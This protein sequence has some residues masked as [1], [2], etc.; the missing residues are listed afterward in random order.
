M[1]PKP[2]RV[3]IQTGAFEFGPNTR[4]YLETESH[5]AHCVGEYLS[6]LLSVPMGHPIPVRA[7]KN[8]GPHHDDI[9]FSLKGP[10]T[11][12]PEGYELRVTR[13]AILISAPRVAG[14]FYAA[15]TLRQMLPAQIERGVRVDQPLKVPC[16]RIQDSPR[17][18]WRGF[19][20]DCSRT[21]LSIAYLRHT[22][23]LMALYKL[24]VLHLHLTDD[25]GWRLEMNEYPEL[26][27][28]GSHFAER[29]G[30]GGGFYS[31]QQMRDLIAYARRRNITIVPEIEMPGHSQEVLAAYPR[32]ACPIPEKKEIFE[33][34][35]FW[36][37]V[38]QHNFSQPLCVCNGKVFEMYRNVLAEVTALFPSQF[39]HVGGDEV[40][41]DAWKAS[42]L[43]QSFMKANGLKN[44][45]QLQSYFMKRIEKV[46]A[47][48]GRRM[49]GWDE[50][51]EGGLAPGAAVMSWRGTNGGMAAT[52]LGH[53]VVMA[54]NPYTYFDY[55]YDT[56]PTQK[57]YSYDPAQGFTSAMARHILGVEAC[58]W[59]HIAVTDREIDYQTYPRLLALSEVGWSPQQDRK[60]SDFDVR[61]RGELRRLQALGVTY[62]DPQAV[63]AKLG[64]WSERD[65]GGGTPRVFQWDV[66]SSML[67]AGEVQVQLR[68]A[69]GKHPFYVRSVELL[70]DGRQAS[71]IVFPAPVNQGNDVAIGWLSPGTRRPGSRYTL[72]VTL[73]GTKDGSS[74]GSVW[75]MKPS[76]AQAKTARP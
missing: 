43:C 47:A 61:L 63:G 46:V 36:N 50:I 25:Q 52:R 49:I 28:V 24:N 14:L 60:W 53:D 58:M 72:R 45:D 76:A 4:V 30:G 35:P 69:G 59:T 22:I 31:Q 40:P 11:L 21:F 32:L 42:P 2:V 74:A 34:A 62:R 33:V 9:V 66:T 13:D 3:E 39:I 51:L 16:V 44:A 64:E 5:D 68:W 71:Q 6:R 12:G 23:D 54:P 29:F 37:F 56:T 7:G 26:A 19:M 67:P 57:V 10:A 73:Q 18:A 8:T 75:I 38:S 48:K 65:L 20:L 70:Q 41:K 15:Q 1:I 27:A 55:T 17:F